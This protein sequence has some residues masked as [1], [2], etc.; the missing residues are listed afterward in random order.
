MHAEQ[1]WI[2]RRLRALQRR[3]CKM[4][5]GDLKRVAI[6]ASA[7]CRFR[8]GLMTRVGLARSLLARINVSILTRVQQPPDPSPRPVTTSLPCFCIKPDGQTVEGFRT[9]GIAA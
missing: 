7:P 6:D 5:S 1:N 8:G 3:V 9:T 4:Q 2:H